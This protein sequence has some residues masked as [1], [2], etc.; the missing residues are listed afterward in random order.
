MRNGVALAGE[1]G[2]SVG[3]QRHPP[4]DPH[5]WRRDRRFEAGSL[6]RR[7]C[8]PPAFVSLAGGEGLA[9]LALRL[10]RIEFL[11]EPLFGG[12]AGVDRAANPLLAARTVAA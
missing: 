12:F 5:C 8:K 3:H 9:G 7:I 10:R 2:V 11:F 6:Q 4:P 1:E